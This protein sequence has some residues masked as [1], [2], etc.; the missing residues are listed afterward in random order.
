MRRR[1]GPI[2]PGTLPRILVRRSRRNRRA[3]RKGGE[4]D[5]RLREAW[6]FPDIEKRSAISVFQSIHRNSQGVDRRS[7]GW[8]PRS[9]RN[10]NRE[11]VRGRNLRR[12]QRAARACIAP[13]QRPGR[14]A[15]NPRASMKI[16]VVDDSSLARSLLIDAINQ[17]ELGEHIFREAGNGIEALERVQSEPPDLILSDLRMPRMNGIELLEEL[18]R[19]GVSVPFCLVTGACRATR[20]SGPWLSGSRRSSPN[21]SVPR[22]WPTP[23]AT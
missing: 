1:T 22:R 14:A 10:A 8:T 18:E 12:W 21:R 16:L 9:C 19:L 3:E 15:S 23:S 7:C 11:N 4:G 17:A 2:S 6:P 20:S 5:R 13:L